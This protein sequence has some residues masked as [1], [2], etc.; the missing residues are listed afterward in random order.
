MPASEAINRRE[1][2]QIW[3]S[4]MVDCA[5]VIAMVGAAIHS[6]VGRDPAVKH[7]YRT[8]VQLP[9]GPGRLVGQGRDGGL[10]MMGGLAARWS[11][12]TG[13]R[14]P[15]HGG[16]AVLRGIAHDWPERGQDE[17]ARRISRV[18]SGRP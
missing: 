13:N 5:T 17:L 3:I 15:G 10:A 4:A 18:Y 8:G 16:V 9:C 6:E 11:I 7:P 12:R 2:Y 14:R 1:A